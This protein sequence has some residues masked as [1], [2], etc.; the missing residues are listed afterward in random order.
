MVCDARG[1]YAYRTYSEACFSIDMLRLRIA[2][3]PKF[4][5]LVVRTTDDYF[6]ADT[7][8]RR[9]ATAVKMQSSDQST[10]RY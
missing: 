3:M 5:D 7:E 1:P 4:R 8:T 10:Y 6:R 9:A 2:Q